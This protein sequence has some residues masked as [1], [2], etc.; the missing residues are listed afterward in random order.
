MKTCE[1][2]SDL[3][4][5]Q[6]L[7]LVLGFGGRRIHGLSLDYGMFLD[8]VFGIL[9]DGDL[10]RSAERGDVEFVYRFLFTRAG[11]FKV[12]VRF[13]RAERRFEEAAVV[14]RVITRQ[15]THLVC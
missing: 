10:R 5:N 6:P 9:C 14:A 11:E 7:E 1:I 3:P 2:V 8:R 15:N 13:E 12:R 4:L